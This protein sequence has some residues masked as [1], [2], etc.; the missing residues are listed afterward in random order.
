MLKQF[1][2]CPLPISRKLRLSVL[3]RVLPPETEEF[4]VDVDYCGARM[5]LNLLDGPQRALYQHDGAEK[6]MLHFLR[7]Y[8][9]TLP[10][11]TTFLDIGANAGNHTFFM[12]QHAD[13]VC[14]FEPQHALSK[15]LKDIV[16]AHPPL[17]NVTVCDFALGTE[18]R[19]DYI[20]DVG[21]CT[22]ARSIIRNHADDAVAEEISIRHGDAAV[23]DLGL[24]AIS[25]VK[26]DVEGYEPLVLTGLA[27]TLRAHRPLIVFEHSEANRDSYD[28]FA[29]LQKLF[30][31]DYEF[32][33]FDRRGAYRYHN[34]RRGF[35]TVFPFDY[36]Q[37]VDAVA[38][39]GVANLI[40]CPKGTAIPQTNF[41]AWPFETRKR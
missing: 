23:R 17:S 6:F 19:T 39:G 3:K 7:D 35:Y 4:V 24:D 32:F 36:D 12:A 31:E 26:I 27:E 1:M 40:A 14:S 11:P 16:A 18:D 20:Y 10:G 29:G 21:K 13:R 38:S 5:P 33:Q 9:N 37:P 41:T 15:R 30:P 2:E 22:G 8:L 28:G 34:A 25:A